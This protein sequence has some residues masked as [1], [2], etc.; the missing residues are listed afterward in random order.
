MLRGG[1]PTIFVSNMDKAVQFYTQ[2]LG[3]PL[4]ARYGD[5]WAEVDAGEGMVL[6]L[7]PHE[8]PNGPRAGTAGSINVGFKVTQPIQKV[9]DT[10]TG[11][12]VHF[13]GPVVRDS[14]GGVNL[15]FFG[16]QDGNA[17]YLCE[18]AY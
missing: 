17:L 15:A 5:K 10:L 18:A 11:R 12:G 16:D 14:E 2:T 7:H 4:K 9:V 8:N 13:H 3:L 1:Y 6:G